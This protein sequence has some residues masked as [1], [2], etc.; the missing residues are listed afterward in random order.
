MPADC[1]KTCP[2]VGQIEASRNFGAEYQGEIQVDVTN[3]RVIVKNRLE[4]Q[5]RALIRAAEEVAA[6]NRAGK[7]IFFARPE[8]AAELEAIGYVREGD[9]PSF[10]NG[11]DAQCYVRFLA[12][13]RSYSQHLADEDKIISGLSKVA[14]T[15]SRV[16]PAGEVNLRRVEEPDLKDLAS[17]FRRCFVSY[18]SPLFELDYLRQLL[19]GGVFFLAAFDG[20]RLVSAASAHVDGQN[21]NAEISDCATDPD[22]RGQGLLTA[23]LDHLAGEMWQRRT[24]VL[25]SLARAGSVGMNV[26]LHKLGYRYQGRLINNCHI[27]GRFENMNLW[28]K[29]PELFH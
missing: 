5:P 22:F 18:P 25:Y 16:A 23:L 26:S 4:H 10:Y 28:V 9:I 7:I 27:A 3:Q 11:L 15:K 8:L 1:S 21:N 19:A 12:P 6:E 24:G 13:D 17:L 29:L 2:P 14:R 20:H